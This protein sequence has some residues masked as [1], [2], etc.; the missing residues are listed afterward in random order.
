MILKQAIVLIKQ[1]VDQMDTSY[2]NVVFDEW[3]ILSLADKDSQV[4]TYVGPRKNE[5]KK[6]FLSDV[7]A[8]RAELRSARQAVGDFDFA[9]HA[10]GTRFDAFLVLGEGLYLICNNT[11]QSMS[12]LTKDSRWLSAQVPFAELTEKFRADPLV[13]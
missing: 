3:A 5:F 13:V 8:L 11:T 7:G 12:A 4:L 6:N 1:C 10:S 9:R 2:Q